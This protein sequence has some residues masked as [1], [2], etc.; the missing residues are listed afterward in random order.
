MAR[1]LG[2]M[3]HISNFSPSKAKSLVFRIWAKLFPLHTAAWEVAYVAISEMANAPVGA[4]QAQLIAKWRESTLAQLSHV[5]IIVSWSGKL[6]RPLRNANHNRFKGAVM[7]AAVVGSFSWPV[8]SKMSPVP[9]TMIRIAWYN[10]LILGIAAVAVGMQ[11]SVFLVRVGCVSNSDM[12]IRELLTYASRTGQRAPYWDQLVIWQAAVALLEW[13]IYFWIGGYVVFI[14]DLTQVLRDGQ[15]KVDQVVSCHH[16]KILN[17]GT[18]TLFS[19][20]GLLF[21]RSSV[22]SLHIYMEYASPLA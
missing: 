17:I 13:S 12:L 15:E 20:G 21:C 7:S 4:E 22:R 9:L 6:E 8:L 18:H 5:G 11:Q 10:S 14:W 19:G 16:W 3:M 1:R 2:G